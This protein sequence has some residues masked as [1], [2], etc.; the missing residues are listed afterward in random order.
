MKLHCRR[1]SRLSWSDLMWLIS[2]VA[3]PHTWKMLDCAITLLVANEFAAV[4][5]TDL[6][7][8]KCHGFPTLFMTTITAAELSTTNISSNRLYP[9]SRNVE[10]QNEYISHHV[11]CAVASNYWYTYR[12]YHME[13]CNHECLRLFKIA[14]CTTQGLT[15]QRD[16]DSVAVASIETIYV[17]ALTYSFVLSF[18]TRHMP[19]DT[20]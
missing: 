16:N 20:F 3:M 2:I 15:K 1:H 10:Q 18:F 4:W 6:W 13:L 11:S 8:S 19:N 17:N 7:K 9:W 14:D 12:R 5:S